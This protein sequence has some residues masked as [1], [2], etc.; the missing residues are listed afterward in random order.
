MKER[1]DIPAVDA[2]VELG[3]TAEQVRQ[4]LEGGW[5]NRVSRSGLPREGEIAARH[6]FTFFNLIFAVLAF[7]LVLVESSVTNFGFLGVVVLNL[8]IGIAQEIRAKRALE[9]LTLVARQQ[10]SAVRGGVLTEVPG[11]ELVRDDI[12]F[13]RGGDHICADGVVRKGTLLVNES[14]ITGE[15]DAI[16]KTEGDE[17]VS[18]SFVVA[19]KAAVQLTR[20]GD[21]SYA[22]GLAAE[23]KRS[24]KVAKS[25]MMADLT[26][27]VHILGA[28]LLPL[29]IAYYLSALGAG[30]KTA[31]EQTVAALVSLIPQGLYLLTSVALAVSSIKLSRSRV[32]ARDMGC[33]EIL[34][35]TDVLC[36][37]KTGT[38]TEPGLQVEE[39]IPLGGTPELLEGVLGG[40]YGGEPENET[41]RAIGELYPTGWECK[42]RI[43][44]T[45]ERKWCG[46]QFEQ[47][48]FLV[49]APE[50]VLGTRYREVC[51]LIQ[52]WSEQGCR[53]LL[54]AS[55]EGGLQQQLQ[56]DRVT[57]LALIVLAGRIRENAAETFLFFEKQ[58]V[59]VKVISGDDPRAV[60]RIARRACI[61]GAEHF[62][63][64]TGLSDRELEEQAGKCT[65]FG[66]VSPRQKRT[67]V[68][69]LQKTHTVA[70]TGDGVNDVLA[71]RQ[72]DCAVAMAGGAQAAAQAA[73]LVLVDGDF[74]GMPRIVAEGRRVV[75]N[76]RRA[77]ALFLVKNIFTLATVL[78]AMVSTLSYPFQPVHL[79][80][81][82][83]LTVGIPSF[84]FA[85]E[86]NRERIT[87]DF[88]KTAVLTAL[89]GGLAA[90]GAVAL[91]QLAGQAWALSGVQL[92]TVCAA[93]LATVGL[94]VLLKV[95]RPMTAMRKGVVIGCGSLLVLVFLLPTP[96][97]ALDV[98]H[99]RTALVLAAA[100]ITGALF[101][102]LAERAPCFFRWLCG[103][104][105]RKK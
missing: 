84:F 50:R 53:V 87:G 92:S 98:Y 52:P 97:L 14:L 71:M 5:D 20:V 79:T 30:Q 33:I 11:E 13:L 54:A 23:A 72:A 66:R 31:A 21:D 24:A 12:V 16:E 15:P 90:F 47:G 74:A 45:S 102:W 75:G 68:A 48:V 27:L 96:Y 56:Y 95:C 49:G 62:V 67:L 9:K 2:A 85:L 7:I 38:I 37:D 58:G 36:V 81:V 76:I 39:V 73:Q 4:R 55:Y 1:A 100:V 105:K 44:F 18:G 51:D 46:G 57:P 93:A 60:S 10:V 22:A 61:R 88:L 40:L 89:P 6:V 64:C 91:A 101:L 78:T 70:M 17:L 77:A 65:V 83:A 8:T 32:L 29:G 42:K 86:P 63:D 103:I 25:P 34:A 59:T 104:L 35:R 41:A 94:L 82:M 28:L 43:P 69:A 3:L 80:V 99:G 19:G 26:R